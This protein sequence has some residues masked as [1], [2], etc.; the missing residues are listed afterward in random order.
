MQ[1]ADIPAEGPISKLDITKERG[2]DLEGRQVAARDA[3][4][5]PTA[6]PPVADGSPRRIEVA[7]RGHR[8]G[9]RRGLHRITG[10]LTLRLA[11]AVE[12]A[13]TQRHGV[14]DVVETVDVH[15]AALDRRTQVGLQVGVALIGDGARRATCGLRGSSAGAARQVLRT[16]ARRETR[17]RPRNQYDTGAGGDAGDRGRCGGLEAAELPNDRPAVGGVQ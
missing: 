5:F 17:I 12:R 9:E 11:H 15:R 13:D 2:R 14:V 7:G 6:P 8:R 1:V 16:I 10:D 3:G 4:H